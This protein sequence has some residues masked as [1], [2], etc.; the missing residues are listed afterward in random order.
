MNSKKI[1]KKIIRKNE[2]IYEQ[3][4]IFSRIYCNILGPTHILPDYII[5]G[6]AKSGTTSLYEYMIKNPRIEPAITKQIH[7]FDKYFSRGSNWYK[8]TFP[9]KSKKN[10]I[11]KE[12]GEFQTGEATPMYR[13][14]VLYIKPN[15]NV[16]PFCT[17]LPEPM[18]GSPSTCASSF[19]KS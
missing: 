8:T 12:F 7:Y 5:I 13:L 11:L 17:Y 6:A 16:L 4:K 10:K 15:P 18:A 9:K 1:V 3:S 2:K 19:V 14:S